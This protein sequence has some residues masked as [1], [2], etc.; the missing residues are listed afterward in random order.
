[1]TKYFSLL[2]RIEIRMRYLNCVYNRNQYNNI[3]KR[4]GYD[5]S[6]LHYLNNKGELI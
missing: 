4:K 6:E 5:G 1:M 3:I 2:P